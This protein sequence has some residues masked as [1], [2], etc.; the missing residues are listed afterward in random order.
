MA[1]VR[2]DRRQNQCNGLKAFLQQGTI[3]RGGLRGFLEHVHHGH[4]LSDGRVEFVMKTDVLA[5]LLDGVVNRT[6]NDFLLVIEAGDV[7]CAGQT[8]AHVVVSQTPDTL[9][10]AVRTFNTR[11]GPFQAR[12][13]WRANSSSAAL[14][15]ASSFFCRIR[16]GGLPSWAGTSRAACGR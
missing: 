8:L 1:D 7:Q 6:A 16:L 5:G 15:M 3:L 4:D 2:R 13:R 10:E 14:R 11:V 12:V 9:E